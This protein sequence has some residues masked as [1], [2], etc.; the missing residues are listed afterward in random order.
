MKVRLVLNPVTGGVAVE[1]DAAEYGRGVSSLC[2][3]SSSEHKSGCPLALPARLLGS[4]MSGRL[5]LPTALMQWSTAPI[6]AKGNSF[7]SAPLPDPRSI[8]PR[9]RRQL[10]M[11]ES[12][13]YLRQF[14]H[15]RGPFGYLQL[16]PDPFDGNRVRR[17]PGMSEPGLDLFC[18]QIAK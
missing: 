8:L 12:C 6:R 13:H 1:N 18:F 10:I 2:G 3:S 17:G 16:E 4:T 5:T 11:V 15:S 9:Q 7:I 14:A